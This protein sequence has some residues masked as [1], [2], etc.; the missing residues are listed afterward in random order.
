ME[1][2][3]KNPKHNGDYKIEWRAV[4]KRIDKLASKLGRPNNRRDNIEQD[5]V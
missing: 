4:R 5:V 3:G 1:K 2:N